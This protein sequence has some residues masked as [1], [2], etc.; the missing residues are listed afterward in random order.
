[1]KGFFMCTHMCVSA[2]NYHV[3]SPS[4]IQTARGP[5]N[6]RI[7][8]P[9]TLCVL[10]LSNLRGDCP[11]LLRLNVI[12]LRFTDTG[13]AVLLSAADRDSDISRL[14]L[15]LGRTLIGLV[16]DLSKL[17]SVTDDLAGA[18]E[19][20]HKEGIWAKMLAAQEPLRMVGTTLLPVNVPPTNLPTTVLDDIASR[21]E[22]EGGTAERQ[23]AASMAAYVNMK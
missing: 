9:C 21:E 22:G 5:I 2:Q 14:V 10:L 15:G 3:Y 7:C 19:N 18:C 8:F 12:P 17:Q 1:M 20:A 16:P 6:N 23:V 11:R 4:S 13:D